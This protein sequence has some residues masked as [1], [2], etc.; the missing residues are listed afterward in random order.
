[1]ENKNIG[2]RQWEWNR[3]S[4]DQVCGD[5]PTRYPRLEWRHQRFNQNNPM[6]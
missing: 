2:D 4:R 5:A 6:T 3:G 1:M